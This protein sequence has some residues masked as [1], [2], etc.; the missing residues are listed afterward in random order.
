MFVKNVWYIAGHSEELAPEG[1]LGRIVAG[2]RI[3]F[4]R[5]ADGSVYALE[6]QCPHRRAPLSMGQIIAGANV[7]C[8]YHGATFDSADKF[9]NVPGQDSFPPDRGHPY[10]PCDGGISLYMGLDWRSGE[11]F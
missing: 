7:R 1:I 8:A 6:D 3:A 4:C 11:V 2:E 10:V 9:V 5:R